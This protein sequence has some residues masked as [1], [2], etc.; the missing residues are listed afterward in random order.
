MGGSSIDQMMRIHC[1]DYHH[2]DPRQTAFML[3][4]IIKKIGFDIILCGKKA[5]DTNGCQVGTY[6]AENLSI[7]Q[8][9][10]IVDLQLLFQEKKAVVQ[11]YLGKGD[12]QE[13][14]CALP[15]LFSTELGMRDPRY[16][17]LPNRMLA[18]EKIIDVI[19]PVGFGIMIPEPDLMR[20]EKFSF[21]RPKTRKIFTPDSNLSVMDRMKAMVSGG[22]TKKEGG[23]ILDGDA[24]Q[25]AAHMLEF[26]RQNKML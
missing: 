9:S 21:P 1:E 5:T 18:E 2:I 3:A 11:K 24:D 10:G 16:P 15:C 4:N 19:D 13:V 23:M 8:V 17:S 26:L 14:E 22:G 20:I 12:R 6:I 7:P 25:L